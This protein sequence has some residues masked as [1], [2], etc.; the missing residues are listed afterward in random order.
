M[1]QDVLDLISL[2]DLYTDADTVDA[3]LDEDFLIVIS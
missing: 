1:N 3:R 2:L